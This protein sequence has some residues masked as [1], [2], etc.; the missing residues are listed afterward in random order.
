MHWKLKNTFD[1][2]YRDIHSTAVVFTFFWNRCSS[3]YLPSMYTG[4][5]VVSEE[6]TL[7]LFSSLAGLQNI[8]LPECSTGG[9]KGF[10]FLLSYT[11]REI[12]FSWQWKGSF[13][14]KAFRCSRC[15]ASLD[16]FLQRWTLSATLSSLVLSP[17]CGSL[18]VGGESLLLPAA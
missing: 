1:S 6:A 11:S 9:R 15:M 7:F 18:P 17:A 13:C 16:Y 10:I 14:W 12:S 2:I 3:L 5:E 4:V 8:N